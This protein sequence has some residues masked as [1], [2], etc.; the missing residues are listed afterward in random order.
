MLPH[1]T[2]PG[3]YPAVAKTDPGPV[4]LAMRMRGGL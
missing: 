4:E 3:Y 1:A 2:S